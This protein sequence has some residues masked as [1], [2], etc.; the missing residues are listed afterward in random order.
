MELVIA[1]G[2]AGKVREFGALLADLPLQT[3]AQPEGQASDMERR[4]SAV[5]GHCMFRADDTAQFMLKAGNAWALR[6]EIRTQNG[7]DR[8]YVAFGNPLPAVRNHVCSFHTAGEATARSAT[9]LAPPRCC[10]AGEAGVSISRKERS[11]SQS[12]LL[13]LL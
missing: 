9:A 2:N 3:R 12:G 4:R 7:V 13:S 6:E 1:S 11:S 10:F 5:D 8:R